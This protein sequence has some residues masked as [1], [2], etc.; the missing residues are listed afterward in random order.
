MVKTT[1]PLFLL[2]Q[3]ADLGFGCARGGMQ[4]RS[5]RKV[6]PFEFIDV[7]YEKL[8][9]VRFRVALRY[10]PEIA[11]MAKI[12]PGGSPGFLQ[13]T[14]RFARFRIFGMFNHESIATSSQR[15]RQTKSIVLFGDL[16]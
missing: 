3:N 8:K 16:Y 6:K 11:K 14:G 9:S 10:L 2:H 5:L 7:L 15:D 1:K 4:T 12:A 13:K